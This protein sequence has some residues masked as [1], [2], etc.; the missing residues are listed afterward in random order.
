MYLGCCRQHHLLL[1]LVALTHAVRLE[2]FVRKSARM[3]P[4]HG[5]P[6]AWPMLLL[7]PQ[8]S[9]DTFRLLL[10]FLTGAL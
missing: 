1:R 3:G 6:L 2:F 5:L 10:V 7:I 9:L 8:P 4:L